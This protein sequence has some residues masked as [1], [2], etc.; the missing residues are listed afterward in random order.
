MII[1]L[2]VSQLGVYCSVQ[3]RT[4]SDFLMEKWDPLAA[5]SSLKYEIEELFTI[6]ILCIYHWNKARTWHKTVFDNALYFCF[7]PVLDIHSKLAQ[8]YR[9]L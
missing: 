1:S 4:L 5:L 3:V 6:F 7:P 8:L 9:R 2:A